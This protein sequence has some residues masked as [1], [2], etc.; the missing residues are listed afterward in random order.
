M[1]KKIKSSV[2]HESNPLSVLGE[3][4]DA[5]SESIDDA[6]TDATAAAKATAL[7][8]KSSVGTGAY[9]TAYGVSYGV[10]F[11]GVFLKELLP[12]SNSFRRGLEDGAQAAI[13]SAVN[14]RAVSADLEEKALEEGSPED[15][16][17]TA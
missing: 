9:Y 10:V 11:S 1:T 2:A 17:G 14:L 16:G 7:K 12:A 8:V 3:A 4:L 6:R 15:A 5:A 13:K